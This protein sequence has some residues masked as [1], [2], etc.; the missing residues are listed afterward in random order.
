MGPVGRDLSGPG[1]MEEP[2]G[3]GTRAAH[4]RTMRAR[5]VDPAIDP[6]GTNRA[7]GGRAAPASVSGARLELP[8]AAFRA[9]LVLDIR[10]HGLAWSVIVAGILGSAMLWGSILGLP[11]AHPDSFDVAVPSIAVDIE[12]PVEIVR[13]E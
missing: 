6:I 11:M 12:H 7:T 3:T 10:Q 2:I 5:R 8:V 13:A 9:A 4:H 1:A